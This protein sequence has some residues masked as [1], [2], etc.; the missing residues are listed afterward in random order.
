MENINQILVN[1]KSFKLETSLEFYTPNLRL[2]SLK[3]N[4]LLP[5]INV[6]TEKKKEFQL[7]SPA[8]S[9]EERIRI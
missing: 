2:L 1:H 4:V 9:A 3:R 7:F 6:Y 5:N 8:K